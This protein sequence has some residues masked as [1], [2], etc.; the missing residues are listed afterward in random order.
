MIISCFQSCNSFRSVFID[1]LNNLVL[2]FIGTDTGCR[3]L[4]QSCIQVGYV[5][6]N[7]IFCFYNSPILDSSI[8]LR[9]IGVSCIFLEVFLHIGN[10]VIQCLI[11]TFTGCFFSVICSFTSSCLIVVSC[12]QSCNSFR[13]VF[14]DLFNNFILGFIGT[15]AGCRFLCQSCIQVGY[16]ITNRIFCF[17]NSPILDSSIILRHIGVSCIFLE[18]FL[19]IGNP[20]IQCL[21]ST[22]TGCFFSVICS[23]TSSCL[24]VVSCFQ[25]CNSFRSVFIDLF[26]NFILGFIGTDAGCRFLCQSCIQVGY[27]ITN[28][29]FCFYNSS[30][31]DSSS[32]LCYIGVSCIF[33]EIF[34]HIG[35]P[36]IQGCFP[37]FT[38]S[39]FSCNGRCIGINGR[40][41]GTN[42]RCIGSNGRFIGSNGRCIGSN[43]RFIRSNGRCIGINGRF[44]GSNGRCIGINGR[45]IGSNGCRVITNCFFVGSDSVCIGGNIFRIVLRC[46]L[47]IFQLC[48]SLPVG[49]DALLQFINLLGCVI[50]RPCRLDSKDGASRK[51]HGR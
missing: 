18:V 28:R 45:F 21:I 42:S 23:F 3:F 38:G 22:F 37:I 15:D 24:I 14:I 7:R 27:V 16:V 44:I 51:N 39:F 6:T 11:S 8:I 30:I 32:I 48:N 5:I 9:H 46:S 17:Y 49:I 12:F 4:C 40:F 43:G 26:N 31:L 20:V 33:L 41:I 35:D 1:L 19:H 13:S 10:P 50:S 36:V 34:L 47:C 2:G 25:S 29:I